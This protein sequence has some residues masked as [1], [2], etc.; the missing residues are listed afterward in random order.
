MIYSYQIQGEIIPKKNR[1]KRG[2]YGNVY[3]E[4]KAQDNFDDI[5]KQLIPRP[6]LAGKCY[7]RILIHTKTN[8][9]DLDGQITTI[10]DALQSSGVIVNDRNIK[11]IEA[12]KIKVKESPRCEIKISLLNYK[13]L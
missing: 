11:H 4:K 10:A 8:R 2:R 13:N 1:W 7:V 5:V 3:L 6:K 12:I 9:A